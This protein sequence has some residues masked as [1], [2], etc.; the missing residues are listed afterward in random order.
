FRID[1]L[2][3]WV[4]TAPNRNSNYEEPVRIWDAETGKLTVELPKMPHVGSANLE[5]SGDGNWLATS[6]PTEYRLW[7]TGTWEPGPIIH[8]YRAGVWPRE[9]GF[10][11]DGQMWVISKSKQS[12]NLLS[13]ASAAELFNLE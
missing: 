5:F 3:R 12:V 1:P 13:T 10:S 6:V 4:V 2:G 8:R 11:R 7:K 9:M